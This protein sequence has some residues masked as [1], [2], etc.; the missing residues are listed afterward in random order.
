MQGLINGVTNAGNQ[1]IEQGKQTG[2]GFVNNLDQTLTSTWQQLD[3]NLQND[4]LEPFRTF[5]KPLRVAM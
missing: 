4:F 3:T 2:I 1:F 5:G